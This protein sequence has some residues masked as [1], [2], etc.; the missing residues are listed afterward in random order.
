M[1]KASCSQIGRNLIEILITA[2]FHHAKLVPLLRFD[3]R[4]S[5]SFF[6]L[7]MVSYYGTGAVP[8]VA[9]ETAAA[10]FSVN[11]HGW[12]G[13]YYVYPH[14]HARYAAL[15]YIN[16]SSGVKKGVKSGARLQD[17]SWRHSLKSH[18]QRCTVHSA[19][20]HQICVDSPLV[21]SFSPR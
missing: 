10:D 21:A 4:H 16:E 3:K 13:P 17:V 6:S 11:D 5:G 20:V 14:D 19:H 8:P 18:I 7:R 1:P 15:D 9:P 2:A 12:V